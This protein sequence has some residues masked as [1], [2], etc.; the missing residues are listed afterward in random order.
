MRIT[1]LNQQAN[2]SQYKGNYFTVKTFKW[3]IQENSDRRIQTDENSDRLFNVDRSSKSFESCSSIRVGFVLIPQIHKISITTTGSSIFRKVRKFK[4][5][6]STEAKIL[7]KKVLFRKKSSWKQVSPVKTNIVLVLNI[8]FSI[9]DI[10]K[11]LVLKV[12][13]WKHQ[14][15]WVALLRFAC[16]G[17]QIRTGCS[18]SRETKFYSTK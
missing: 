4:D 2:Y 12:R 6:N 17:L 16:V 14:T 18:A 1:V 11:R 3:T 10:L 8:Y 7:C 5:S 13:L 15:C 9:S